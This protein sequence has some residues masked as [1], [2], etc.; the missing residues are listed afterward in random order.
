[1][2][3]RNTSSQDM[4]ERTSERRGAVA[5]GERAAERAGMPLPTSERR[6]SGVQETGAP[7]RAGALTLAS[8]TFPGP[9][10]SG[11]ARERARYACASEL[12]T[13]VVSVYF[14]EE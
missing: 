8:G 10:T 3:E 2:S 14:D 11:L 7:E 13:L 6:A 12:H 4:S 5:E 9:L 1:M